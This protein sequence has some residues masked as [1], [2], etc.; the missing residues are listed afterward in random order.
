MQLKTG[1]LGF[2]VLA[3]VVFSAFAPVNNGAENLDLSS[4]VEEPELDLFTLT[5]DWTS[6]ND[7]E[8]TLLENTCSG[9]D[10][11]YPDQSSSCTYTIQYNVS[12]NTEGKPVELRY[13]Y[14]EN[15]DGYG[16]WSIKTYTDLSAENQ[17]GKLTRD[18]QDADLGKTTE[19][20]F[21]VESDIDVIEL[22]YNMTEAEGNNDQIPR[23]DESELE[24]VASSEVRGSGLSS[25]ASYM[26]TMLI[27]WGAVV[28]ALAS[29][30][31]IS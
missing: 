17:T 19:E 3:V 22:Q 8:T 6:P 14:T 31:M 23:I 5:D 11:I 25:D 26:I 18:L 4:Q 27:F 21:F 7:P 10:S 29:S 1:A 16:S 24:Y 12:N 9:S 2:V 20:L 15:D 30:F 28:I 13:D